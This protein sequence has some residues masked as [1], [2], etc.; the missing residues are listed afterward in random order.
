M[1]RRT[2]AALLFVIFCPT[3]QAQI[4][5]DVVKIGLLTDMS[6]L[7]SEATGAGSAEAIRLAIADFGG[8]VAGKPV[9]LLTADCQLKADVGASIAN[10]WFDQRKVDVIVGG[11]NS[12]VALAVQDIARRKNKIALWSEAGS[13]DL[14]GKACSP[15]SIQWTYD[16][17]ALARAVAKGVVSEGG[18]TWFFLTA[19]YAFGQSLERDASD[20]VT[21]AGGKV[22]GR[23]RHPLNTADF[24]SFL[25]QAQSSGAQIIGL[26]NAAN[27]MTNSIK[28][29]AEFRIPQGGKQRLAGLLVLIT[30][31]HALGI[32]TTQGLVLASGFYWNRDAE[33][34]A[35]GKRFFEKM[36]RMPTM[37]QA[38]LYSAVHHYLSAVQAAGTDK[39]SVVLEKMRSTPVND[40]M[41]HDG[42]IR[43]DGRMIYDF[44]LLQV[45]QPSESKEPWD[46]Y[47][48]LRTLRG[49][50]I[51]RP[52]AESTCPL[53]KR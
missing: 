35:W 34:R 15:T 49:D 27:D 21:A 5:D 6:S 44:L 20:V 39:T 13:S 40:M 48:V 28:Q 19:D 33:S 42:R 7:Y 22:L 47:Q 23:V 11:C 26:A 2:V 51:F 1:M 53:I 29:A 37:L 12:A 41:V 52:L 43:E 25:L 8:K 38:G 18:K 4:S 36:H 14:T 3:A 9:E 24:S 50:E 16:T 17:Y 46:Y 32:Q 31:V 45:K 30:D 10:E